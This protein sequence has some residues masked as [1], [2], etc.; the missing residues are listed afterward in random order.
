MIK[1]GDRVRFLN[2]VGGGLV[3]RIDKSKFLVY[4]EDE[5]GFE[6]P[7]LERE[8]VVVPEVNEKTNFPKKDFS[9]KPSAVPEPEIIEDSPK[10]IFEKPDQIFETPEGE[11]LKVLL[12][13]VPQKIKEIHTTDFDL[14]LV[15]DSNYFVFYNLIAGDGDHTLSVANGRIEPNMQEQLI[16]FDNRNLEKFSRLSVQLMAFKLDKEYKKQQVVDKFIKFDPI[17][18]LKLHSYV[19]ND[20]F[21][22][23]AFIFD[24]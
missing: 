16:S 13:F 5:D 3:T 6:V 14:I 10:K 23:N 20:Y 21:D 4:V 12:A 15:N 17:K 22:E 9:S 24:I 11:T 19:T 18:F 2:N 1:T 8:C 7:V